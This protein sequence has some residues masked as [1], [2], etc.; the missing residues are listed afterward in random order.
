MNAT[1]DYGQRHKRKKERKKK[2]KKKKKNTQKNVTA[3]AHDVSP[4]PMLSAHVSGGPRGNVTKK[5]DM[6]PRKRAGH[7]H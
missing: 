1:E 5:Q 2:K 4:E 7:A 6:R 3:K